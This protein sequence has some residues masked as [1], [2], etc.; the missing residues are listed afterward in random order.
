MNIKSINNKFKTINNKYLL[1]ILLFSFILNGASK[2]FAQNVTCKVSSVEEFSDCIKNGKKNLEIKYP[3]TIG[4]YNKY[5][6]VESINREKI[7]YNLNC[8]QF[9]FK[10]KNEFT[11]SRGP[12]GKFIFSKFNVVSSE[13]IPQK[14]MFL[15]SIKGS[16]YELNFFDEFGAE[17]QYK[18]SGASFKENL[19]AIILK[20]VSGLENN[21]RKSEGEIKKILLEKLK[22]IQEKKSIISNNIFL[23]FRDNEDCMELDIVNFPD[24]S[25]RVLELDKAETR[26][27]KKLKINQELDTLKICK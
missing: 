11:V 18:F 3:I 7:F 20:N 2:I 22:N 8:L 25:N 6:F 1:M 5:K 27:L 17:R 13:S 4:N 15:W 21:S 19:L 24:L 14:D 16:S 9:Y 26:L 10:N 23:N 12:V